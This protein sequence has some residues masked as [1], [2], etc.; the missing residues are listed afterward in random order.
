MASAASATPDV[1][2]RIASPTQAR[3]GSLR[4]R[5]IPFIAPPR[6]LL[7]SRILAFG[8]AAATRQCRW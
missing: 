7:L 2:A 4:D 1:T 6:S 5:E 8:D 3:V